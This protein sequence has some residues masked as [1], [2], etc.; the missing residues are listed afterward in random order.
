MGVKMV[1]NGDQNSAAHITAL[2]GRLTLSPLVRTYFEWAEATVTAP[3]LLH[4]GQQCVAHVLPA[5]DE[6]RERGSGVARQAAV[7]AY[8]Y[9]RSAT[10]EMGDCRW[11]S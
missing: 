9:R 7:A 4:P 3:L 1:R 8:R 5:V 11:G 2:L 10:P 6:S